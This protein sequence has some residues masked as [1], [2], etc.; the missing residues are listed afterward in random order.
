MDK[1]MELIDTIA[2]IIFRVVLLAWLIS[3]GV[4]VIIFK[5]NPLVVLC[6]LGLTVIAERV[7][8]H[9]WNYGFHRRTEDDVWE[10]R[11][12]S[13]IATR[14]K[15]NRQATI[16]WLLGRHERALQFINRADWAWVDA[17]MML[18]REED[19]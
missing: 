19:Y 12:D 6:L 13:A 10:E 14:D 1:T 8:M 15:L 9:V 3:M 2:W 11:Y 4:A 7:I 5:F 16:W 17:Q 18:A